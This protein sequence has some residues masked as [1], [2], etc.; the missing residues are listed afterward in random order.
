MKTTLP[1]FLVL[2]VLTGGLLLAGCSSSSQTTTTQADD[3]D[4]EVDVG[5]GKQKEKDVTGAV[6][7]VDADEA[8]REQPTGTIADMLKGRVAGVEVVGNKVYIRGA[9]NL[10]GRVEPLIVLDGMAIDGSAGSTFINPSDVKSISVLKD[11][12]S[13]AIYGSRGAN[14]VIVIETKRGNE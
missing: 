11:A 4:E 6:D 10:R 14:G 9:A 1:R 8:R 13:T 5:Y 3:G 2:L 7:K 12:A